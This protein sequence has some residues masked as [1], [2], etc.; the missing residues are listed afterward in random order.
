[1]IIS[2]WCMKNQFYFRFAKN[3]R[4]LDKDNFVSVPFYLLL[5]LVGLLTSLALVSFVNPDVNPNMY[6]SLKLVTFS[7]KSDIEVLIIDFMRS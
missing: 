4:C 5:R 3:G 1:M 7:K 6:Y 2:E